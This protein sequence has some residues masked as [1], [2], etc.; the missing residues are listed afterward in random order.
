[1]SGR[2]GKGKRDA[3]PNGSTSGKEK[4]VFTG[5][6][7]LAAIQ[8]RLKLVH[9]SSQSNAVDERR[10]VGGA[11]SGCGVAAAGDCSVSGGVGGGVNHGKD[12]DDVAAT[13]DSDDDFCSPMSRRVCRSS[14]VQ[15]EEGVVVLKHSKVTRKLAG[16]IAQMRAE[17]NV[18]K[19]IQP[20]ETAKFAVTHVLR[21]PGFEVES[22]STFHVGNVHVIHRFLDFWCDRT[23]SDLPEARAFINSGLFSQTLALMTW[24]IGAP[25]AA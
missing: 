18:V 16:M 15:S 19:V 6:Q 8:N 20:G 3:Y 23:G 2:G 22:L 5:A 17:M 11:A 12:G 24:S 4:S 1:M 10:G 7:M 9:E 13:E 21:E 25:S 14:S